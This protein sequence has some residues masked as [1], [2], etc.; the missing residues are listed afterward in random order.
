MLKSPA[1]WWGAAFGVAGVWAV[2]HFAI[3]LP[4]AKK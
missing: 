3:P 4:G 1:F 2:H